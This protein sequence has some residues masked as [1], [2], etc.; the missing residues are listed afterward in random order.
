MPVE[1][2]ENEPVKPLLSPLNMTVPP[3]HPAPRV[4]RGGL[5]ES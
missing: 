2:F 1:G 3:V 4:T 5:R